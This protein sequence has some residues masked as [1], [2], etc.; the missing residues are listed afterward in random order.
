MGSMGKDMLAF[1]QGKRFRT[2]KA[3]FDYRRDWTG[4]PH[5]RSSFPRSHPLARWARK[6]EAWVA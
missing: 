3:S 5:I 2:E 6:V 4:T 1:S